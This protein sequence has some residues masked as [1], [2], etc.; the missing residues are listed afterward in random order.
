MTSRSRFWGFRPNLMVYFIKRHGL[1]GALLWFARN[2]PKY[3]QTLKRWGPIRTHLIA[4]AIS[5][6]NGCAYCTRGHI[7]AFQ[8]H[9]LKLHDRLFPLDDAEF[10]A[11][12]ERSPDEMIEHLVAVLL[13]ADLAD[14]ARPLR[15][16]FEL[17]VQ[18][19]RARCE[20]DD[21]FVQLIEMLGA[22]NE[23]DGMQG[24]QMD[25]VHDPIVEDVELIHRY[26]GL[27]TA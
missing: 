5:T 24:R 12:T 15:R 23:C 3:E 9:Y 4:A 27:R 17:Y 26:D 10:L 16:A 8:L 2:M 21:R 22:F 1:V 6:L 13:R 11:L 20:E 7:R 18:P 25:H 19:E 14:E